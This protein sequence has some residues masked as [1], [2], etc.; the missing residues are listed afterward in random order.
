MAMFLRGLVG[1]VGLF[2]F[3][4]A[5]DDDAAM[6][7][8]KAVKL[9]DNGVQEERM[10]EDA[11]RDDPNLLEPR[12]NLA[13][14]YLE[15]GREE[16]AVFVLEKALSR[17]Q[18]EADLFYMLGLAHARSGNLTEA[19]KAFEQCLDRDP[20]NVKASYNLGLLN[21]NPR[22][23]RG[24]LGNRSRAEFY[25][26][27]T[28]AADREYVPAAEALLS[29]YL[30]RRKFKEGAAVISAFPAESLSPN[31]QLN[32]A[33]CMEEVGN[34]Q[35]AAGY[36][37]AYVQDLE[38]PP[39][40]MLKRVAQLERKP[41]RK[42][43]KEEGEKKKGREKDGESRPAPKKPREET[44]AEKEKPKSG[45][46]EADI[47]SLYLS[48][49]SALND[50]KFSEASRLFKQVA[51]LQEEYRDVQWYWASALLELG[52]E[53]QA[54]K[55]L[56]EAIQYNKKHPYAYVTLGMLLEKRGQLDE[57]LKM[58]SRGIDV[59][60]EGVLAPAGK[61]GIERIKRRLR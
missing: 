50:S 26:K 36:L 48:G 21:W 17:F 7:N 14:L 46:P 10:Y 20:E 22:E 13:I 1:L 31:A 54:E 47:S 40:K 42:K 19:A 6:L 58:Y 3:Q 55:H 27:R 60:P 37:K 11:I 49:L 57:A 59:A 4:S 52:E 41:S 29:L 44:P 25:W 15:S 23:K 2:L 9:D 39:K 43:D 56:R 28:L 18:N 24:D 32:A 16:N 33:N 34:D 51:D 12:L 61:Q 38:D 35:E 8:N 53:E 5:T 30:H 45:K